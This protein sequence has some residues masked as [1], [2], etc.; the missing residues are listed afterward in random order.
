M[1][2]A[3]VASNDGDAAAAPIRS[4]LIHQ[5]AGLAIPCDAVTPAATNK[6]VFA[7][8]EAQPQTVGLPVVEDGCPIG[9]INRNIFMQSM[10]RPFH[11]EVFLGKS[12][13]AFMDKAPL[14]VD[15]TTSIQDLSFQVLA[16]GQ[17]AM[18]DGFI[19][20]DGGRYLGIGTAQDML[21][22]VSNLQAEKN[23][24]VME[25][26]DY[27]SVIQQS[28]ARPSREA[29]RKTLADHFMIWEP[30]DVVSGD[31][32]YFDA[33]ADGFL[34]VLFDCTGHGVPGA[35]MTLI[36]S[37]FLR[38]A[39]NSVGRDDPGGLIQ[40]VNR[41]VKT[42]MGNIDHRHAAT[43]DEGEGADDGMDAAFIRVDSRRRTLSYAGAHL[44]ILLL[45][46]DG[47][48][49]E[50]IDGDRHGVGYAATPMDQAWTNHQVELPEGSSVYCFTD[51]FVDQLGGDK[52]I[53]FGKR[54]TREG[55]LRHRRQPMP[56]QR[57]A[58]LAAL[59]AYQ[60]AE[61]RKDDVSA[62]GFR[63]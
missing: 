55:I 54:R 24:L 34:L 26:I 30:R 51:G 61:Q 40:A 22:A 13:I 3:S 63:L 10:A 29:M 60:G 4:A 46:P 49:V 47:E 41:Q 1:N 17:K 33:D 7:I 9:L 43:Q 48:Q 19:V 27:A 53:A 59:Q 36:M 5:T 44:P 20:S 57:T 37:A 23:R 8:F 2:H 11:R 45:R 6:D 35:F 18:N 50:V 12:C 42:A 21:R 52:R 14:I 28:L 15:K 16:S 58:L 56:E 38:S 39:L 62:I 31:F 32:Y 25:S